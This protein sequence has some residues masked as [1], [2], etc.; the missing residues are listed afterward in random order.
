ML[1]CPGTGAPL[2]G[3]LGGFLGGKTATGT[4]ALCGHCV[5]LVMS[6]GSFAALGRAIGVASGLLNRSRREGTAVGV[7]KEYLEMASSG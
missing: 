1:K 6:Q 3:G 7:M 5:G 2:T 4:A